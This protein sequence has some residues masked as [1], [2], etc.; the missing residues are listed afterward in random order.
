MEQAR[1][2]DRQSLFN[3]INRINGQLFNNVQQLHD[4]TQ[5]GATPLSLHC[6]IPGVFSQKSL[7]PVFRHHH[8]CS[9]TFFLVAQTHSNVS[10]LLLVMSLH[11]D[12]ATPTSCHLHSARYHISPPLRFIRAPIA[13]RDRTCITEIGIGIG[14]ARRGADRNG[15]L[16]RGT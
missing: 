8:L 9:E 12:A 14:N 15:V 13:C 16:W 1:E 10:T 11:T 4:A 5:H 2:K 3:R 6:S 7:H